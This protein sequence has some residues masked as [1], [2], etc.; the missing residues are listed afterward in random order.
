LAS[1][2]YALLPTPSK[3]R[4]VGRRAGGLIIWGALRR[5]FA[6]MNDMNDLRRQVVYSHN[7]SAVVMTMVAPAGG[8]RASAGDRCGQRPDGTAGCTA[9]G[10]MNYGGWSRHDRSQ[11][12]VGLAAGLRFGLIS[13]GQSS[14]R[15]MSGWEL[16]MPLVR[17]AGTTRGCTDASWRRD[18]WR[19]I[20]R[21]MKLQRTCTAL[22]F[23]F[24]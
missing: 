22:L 1:P 17:C 23:C 6:P 15:R 16:V 12:D 19:K 10:A 3:P 14:R 2:N 11:P 9:R 5:A 18:K 7:G 21:I 24:L 8:G 4:D 20:R 13:F